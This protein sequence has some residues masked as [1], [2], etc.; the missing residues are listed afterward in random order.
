MTT[1]KKTIRRRRR[2][3][4]KNHYFTQDHE[5]AIVTLPIQGVIN[6]EQICM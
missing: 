4:K 3:G 5:D 6:K 2:S 1:K